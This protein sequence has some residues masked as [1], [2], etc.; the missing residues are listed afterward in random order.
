MPNLR[1]TIQTLVYMAW[2][3]K[4]QVGQLYSIIITEACG[5]VS[6]WFIC[7]LNPLVQSLRVV[8]YHTITLH[9]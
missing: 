5:G 7:K 6:E 4:K 2:W 3:H 1:Y 8:Y 9:R